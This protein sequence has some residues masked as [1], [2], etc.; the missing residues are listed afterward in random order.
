MREARRQHTGWEPAWRRAQ[1]KSSYDVVIIG[2]GGHGLAT[3]YYLAKLHNVTNVA[4]LEKGWLGGGNT[5]RN[6]TII[7][8]NYL[9]PESMALYGLS[10]SLFEHLSGELD[11]NT[12]YSPRGLVDLAYTRSD[13][14]RLS[15]TAD[16]N[17]HFG[18]KSWMIPPDEVRTIVPQ[19]DDGP[20]KRYPLM[21][22]LWQPSGGI[23]RHDAIAWGYARMASRLGVD[24]IENCEA[25][26]IEHEVGRVVGVKTS[27]GYIP[28]STV[29]I[30]AAS[31]TP[32]LTAPL[33]I[34]LPIEPVT[35]QALVSEPLKPFLDVVVMAGSVE[36][37]VSQSDKG[38]LVI[39]GGTDLYP[40]YSR[41]GALPAIED[42]VASLLELFP[43]LSRVRMMRHWGGTVDITPDRSP[44]IGPAGPRGLYLNCGWGTGGFKA[45]PGSGYATA[46]LI[47]SGKAAHV[48][49]PFGLERFAQGRMIDE[50]AASAVAH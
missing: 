23:A 1:P 32:A 19:L 39:G 33:G 18:I 20:R 46:S 5:A 2:G 34:R 14:D 9:R 30:A 29:L 47:T 31:D 11:F 16:A 24:I 10:H 26:S 48:V 41:R 6:T 49:E 3:A 45:I 36:G 28:T 12:F 37:Y 21:G 35:L 8:S 44:I 27:R 7:R 42:T 22:A 15:R 38:E 43:V 17:R 40:G 25:E 13:V 50:S 4:V